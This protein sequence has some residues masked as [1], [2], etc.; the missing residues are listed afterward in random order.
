M[1]EGSQDGL[2]ED[3]GSP[4][5]V[6]YEAEAA[7]IAKLFCM[8]LAGLR[9]NLK[10]WQIPAAIRALRE[11]KQA[12]LRAVRERR[13]AVRHGDRERRRRRLEQNSLT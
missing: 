1:N 6:S 2:P 12:A 7:E 8:K 9:R 5:P 13:A 3:R 4:E 10:P 11:E